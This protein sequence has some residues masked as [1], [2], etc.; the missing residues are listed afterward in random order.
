MSEAPRP[1]FIREIIEEHN[2][3]GRFGGKVVTRKVHHPGTKPHPYVEP[4]F[5]AWVDSLGTMAAEA[6]IKVIKDNG[7]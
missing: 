6:N 7:P 1:N 2:R 3:S 4:A 5:E